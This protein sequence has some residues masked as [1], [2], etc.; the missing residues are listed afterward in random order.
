M[1]MTKKQDPQKNCLAC[2]RPILRKRINGRLEDRGVFL[3]RKYCNQNCMALGKT[4]DNPT[5]SAAHVRARKHVA[6]QCRDCG[7]TKNLHVHHLNR[8]PMDNE[9]A[10]LVTLC[11]S[12]H[13]KL[14]WREDREYRLSRMNL[15]GLL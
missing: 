1:P 2:N 12:C 11:A 15:S 3:R 10:N 9:R 4:K 6:K 8:N 5:K 7:M 14:H 13:L